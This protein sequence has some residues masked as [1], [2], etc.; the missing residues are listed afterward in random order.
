MTLSVEEQYLLELIN[1]ARLDP[2][3][4]AASLGIDLN[5]GLAPGTLTGSAKQ[6]LAHN[7]ILSEAAEG[8]SDWMLANNTFSHAG[9]GG[10]SAGDRMAEAGYTFSGAWTWGENLAWYGTTG[11]VDLASA[12]VTHDNGLFLSPGHRV[13]LL[14]EAY[15]EIG[16]AQVEGAFTHSNGITYN[17]SML[18]EKFAKSGSAVFLTGVAYNDS[19]DDGFYSMGEAEAG[20]SFSVGP[21]STF[22]AA[23]G[24]YELALAAAADVEVQITGVGFDARVSIDLTGGNAKL[25]VVDR[26]WAL[27]SA[28]LTLLEGLEDARLLGVADLQLA[29]SDG[30]NRLIGNKGDNQIFGGGG[31]DVLSGGSGA[32]TL[33]G[34]GGSDWASYSEA[35]E[36]VFVRLWSGEGLSGEAAGD[37]LV[38]IENLRGSA[39]ADTLVGDGGSNALFGGDG[40]DALWAGDGDDVL[41]GGLGAD[42]LQGQ[43]GRD[44]ASYAEAAGG[45]F[46]RLWSGEGLSGE[47]AGDVLVGIENLRGS[48]FADTLVGDGG[49]NDLSGGDGVDALWA[50]EGDDV[51]SG[52]LGADLLQGQGGRDTASYAEAAG[53]VFV[54]L[55]SGEGLSGEA[56]GDVL[57]GIE[58]LRGSAFADTLVGDGGAND[59]SGGD[60]VDALWAGDGDDVL[61]GGLGADL[62]QG[63]GGRDTA[64]YAEAAGGVFVRLWSGEGLSGEAAGDVLVGIENLRGSGFGDTLVGDGGVN[65]LSGGD[66]ADALWAS[67]GDDVLSGGAGADV[68]YGQGG[69]DTFVFTD[70]SGTDTV[71]DWQDGI[72]LLAFDVTG[73]SGPSDLGIEVVGADTIIQ[74]G[75]VRAVLLNWRDG[76]DGM[77]DAFDFV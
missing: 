3:A 39:F 7:A 5:Q 46:V 43:G 63:Q 30:N 35:S 15:R 34:Q 4:K 21:Q 22:S 20:L 23:A 28:D 25:D 8:H 24:G 76:V 42:L 17:A 47:A 69:A 32:D 31:D 71:A 52:G 51:L 66:G 45:V 67:D 61:S 38:G 49:A 53:G 12:I 56:A 2:L 60:G 57:V 64:S 14:A 72:D 58:N 48:A 55:W 6:V 13:N 11:T 74:A 26:T 27:A 29:G 62:L 44:T 9:A 70:G 36:G 75:D 59:L 1:Q 41:S 10:S 73:V 19:D 68:L 50:G 18:T 33:D 65:E 37:V 54:R 77:I 16:I 40:V